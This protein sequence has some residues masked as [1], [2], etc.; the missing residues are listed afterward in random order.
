LSWS[1]SSTLFLQRDDAAAAE[2]AVGGDDEFGLAVE[3]AVGHGLGAEAAED[4][5][6][7]GADAGAGEHGDG[8]FRDHGQIDDDAVAFLDAVALEDVGEEADFAMELLIGEGA[9]FAGLAGA[10]GF[11]L[12]D[13]GCLVGDR[14]A[15]MAVQA[16]V[17]DIELAADKPLGVG[18]LPLQDFFPGLEPD[19][20]GFG[21]AMPEGLGVLDGFAVKLAVLGQGAD[22]GARGEG[23]GRRENALFIE[24]GGEMGWLYGR[25]VRHGGLG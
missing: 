12:P 8:G 20:F 5:G 9:F 13:Q 14:G 7:D 2:S 10:G 21:L 6:M 18:K 22:V 17:A 11:A 25:G 19:Q 24:D 16:I 4:D 3:N 15:E 23:F 1:A